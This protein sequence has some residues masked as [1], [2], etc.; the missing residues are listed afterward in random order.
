MKTILNLIGM[1]LEAVFSRPEGFIFTI[2]AILCIA[3]ILAARK[4]KSKLLWGTLFG[5]EGATLIYGLSLLGRAYQADDLLMFLYISI[6][7][8]IVFFI[9]L[10]ISGISCILSNQ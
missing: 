1:Y 3:L 4:K 9:M 10:V 2:G 7:A 5:I 6:P 8:L